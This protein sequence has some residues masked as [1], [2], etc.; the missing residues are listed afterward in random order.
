MLLKNTFAAQPSLVFQ[1]QETIF[2]T[3]VTTT[4]YFCD[5]NISINKQIK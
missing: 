5:N 3:P 1:A 4:L 2:C